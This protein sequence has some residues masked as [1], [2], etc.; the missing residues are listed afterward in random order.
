MLRIISILVF[1][2]IIFFQ[3]NI[4]ANSEFVTLTF[5]QIEEFAIKNSFELNSSSV[6][7]RLDTISGYLEYGLQATNPQLS[8]TDESVKNGNKSESEQIVEFSKT[9]EM[10]WIYHKRS[11]GWKYRSR[12]LELSMEKFRKEF[13]GKIKIGYVKL[14][15]LKSKV[16]EYDLVKTILKDM[17]SR[18]VRKEKAG[19]LP[20]FKLRLIELVVSSMEYRIS[21]LDVELDKEETRWKH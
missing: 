9:F 17:I 13:L 20:A 4:Y 16:K 3:I 21:E 15:L 6:K 12:A 18:A 7:L 19:F 2:L 14:A 10:P 1:V 5:S 8:I 11:K